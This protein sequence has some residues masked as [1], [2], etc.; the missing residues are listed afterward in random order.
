MRVLVAC[1]FSGRVRDAFLYRGHDAYSCDLLPTLSTIYPSRHFVQDVRP[2]LRQ[3]WDLVIGHPPCTYL[4]NSGVS[5]LSGS[6]KRWEA[7]REACVFFLEL[8][9][10]NS[11]KV[12]VENPIQHRY[13]REII[14]RPPSQYIQPFE[15]ATPE[16]KKTGLWLQR[17]PNLKPTNIVRS[18]GSFNFLPKDAG[19]K[20]DVT[21]RYYH[22]ITYIGIAEAMA[23]QWGGIS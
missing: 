1:E 19:L 14:G 11:P 17:L 21:R 16:S 23:E 22:S 8:L 3:R 7:M 13:A 5:W 20:R 6:R 10:A 15:Y 2:L 12:A 4:A 18:L 9:N